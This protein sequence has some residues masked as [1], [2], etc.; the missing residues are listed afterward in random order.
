MSQIREQLRRH[1]VALISLV[2][3][4]SSL[5]YNSWRNELTEAN[6]NVRA[7]GIELLLTL[8]SLDQVVFFSH[9][10]RDELKG[11]PRTGWAY[12]LTV[13]DLGQLTHNP[14]IDSASKLVSVWQSNWEG[15]GSDDDAAQ[16]ISDAIDQ[17]RN[18][19]LLV[20][21]ELD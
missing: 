14:A 10:E 1:S 7:A 21:S 16:S 15:L 9:Y 8:G 5:G 6:R 3:A 18:D 13:R 2:V 17:T 12:V 19:V 20:L 11:N 4:L